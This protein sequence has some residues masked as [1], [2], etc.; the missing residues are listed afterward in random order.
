[1]TRKLRTL[2]RLPPQQKTP[3]I[4]PEAVVIIHGADDVKGIPEALAL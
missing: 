1:M 4:L 2:T 3:G